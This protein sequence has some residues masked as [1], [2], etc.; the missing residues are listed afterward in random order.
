[1][2]EKIGPFFKLRFDEFFLQQEEKKNAALKE[3]VKE[4]PNMN[5]DQ[6]EYKPHNI[7]SRMGMKVPA[8]KEKGGRRTGRTNENSE[9]SSPI[10]EV[11]E[12]NN[13]F[14]K[15]LARLQFFGAGPK[16]AGMPNEKTS[17]EKTRGK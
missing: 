9:N 6:K 4:E 10:K 8:D 3:E 17:K 2:T 11:D 7:P 16:M 14:S 5:G 13:S 1:M 15:E 12:K